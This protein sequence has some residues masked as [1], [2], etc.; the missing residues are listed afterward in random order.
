MNY[1]AEWKPDHIR[2]AIEHNI[3][4]YKLLVDGE[5]GAQKFLD[6]KPKDITK[7]QVNAVSTED[8][9][10]WFAERRPDLY[11][12]IVE[13]AEGIEWLMKNAENIKKIL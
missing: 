9:L 5:G 13:S 6:L 7:E 1:I 3:D 12:V 8:I 11:A 4:L 10:L 2:G